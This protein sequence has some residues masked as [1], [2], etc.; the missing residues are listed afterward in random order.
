MYKHLFKFNRTKLK[1][2]DARFVKKFLSLVYIVEMIT[3]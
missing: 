3:Y 1:K 2:I